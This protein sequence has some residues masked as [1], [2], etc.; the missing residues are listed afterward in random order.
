MNRPISDNDQPTHLLLAMA[1]TYP[2][3]APDLNPP[4]CHYSL[5][6]GAWILDDTGSLLADSP[7]RPMAATKKMDTETGEDQKGA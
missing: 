4:G 6:E 5:A 2:V 7:V 1:K 3:S